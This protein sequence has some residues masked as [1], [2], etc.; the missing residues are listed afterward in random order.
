[1][2]FMGATQDPSGFYRFKAVWDL[3]QA[4]GVNVESVHNYVTQLQHFFLNQVPE[5][6]LK[7]W[8]LKSLTSSLD[9]HGHF[10]TYE[11][12]TAETGEQLETLL[13]TNGILIDRRGRRLRF[14]FGIYQDLQDVER[15]CESLGKLLTPAQ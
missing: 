4:Q 13:K 10:L 15:L 6:F 2:A 14:G 7:A 8:G 1:M 5:S 12:P 3:W 11:T 9:W